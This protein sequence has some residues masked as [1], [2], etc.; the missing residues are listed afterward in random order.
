MSVMRAE[1]DWRLKRGIASLVNFGN[2]WLFCLLFRLFCVGRELLSQTLSLKARSTPEPFSGSFVLTSFLWICF[3]IEF[4]GIRRRGRT[5][6]Q[7]VVEQ[8]GRAGRKPFVIWVLH[9][10]PC[11]NDSSD[12][13]SLE[14]SPGTSPARCHRFSR[15]VAQNTIEAI[16]FLVAALTAGFVKE[17]VF[18]GYIQ[19]QCQV[20]CGSTIPASALQVL[21]FTQGR[22][23]FQASAM[24][25]SRMSRQTSYEQNLQPE[26][27]QHAVGGNGHILMPIHRKRDGIRA[28]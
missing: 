13:E 20:L 28:D 24:R 19:R 11:G 27:I 26:N 18:R 25:P 12:R 5:T 16:G 14:C 4:V 7:E 9:W 8:N 15:M 17:F 23:F 10:A 22:F 21:I 6:W 3:A 2:F 1:I